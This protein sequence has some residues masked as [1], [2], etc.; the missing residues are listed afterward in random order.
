VWR[1]STRCGSGACVEVTKLDDT[2]LMRD[3]KDPEGPVLHFSAA[4]WESFVRGVN[5]GDFLF[6]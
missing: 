2:Y 1:K 4:E 6:D 5:A 3:S